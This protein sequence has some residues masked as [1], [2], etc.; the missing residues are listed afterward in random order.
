VQQQHVGELA[1]VEHF[2]DR[3]PDV[4]EHPVHPRVDE[5]R[6]LVGDQ[7]LVELKV[8]AVG[9]GGGDPVDPVDDLVD[10]R[11]G[12]LL[13]RRRARMTLAIGASEI[14]APTRPR[15]GS[16]RRPARSA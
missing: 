4:V 9:I 6:T 3:F 13:T 1:G 10:P 15:P 11:H 7:E 14:S 5:R 16:R 8:E 12:C 2:R